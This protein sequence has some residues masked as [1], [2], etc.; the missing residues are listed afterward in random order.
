MI[1]RN[2]GVRHTAWAK[3]A[4][5]FM[6]TGPREIR[7]YPL[8]GTVCRSQLYSGLM[9][10]RRQCALLLSAKIYGGVELTLIRHWEYCIVKVRLG[11]GAS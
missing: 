6:G 3:E 8:A 2:W 10:R 7:S 5:F 4:L 1:K 11:E 9:Q